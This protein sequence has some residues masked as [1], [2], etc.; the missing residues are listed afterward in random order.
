MVNEW[1]ADLVIPTDYRMVQ[2]GPLAYT[3]EL[4]LTVDNPVRK[5]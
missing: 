5:R 2:D 3:E 1:R 4:H